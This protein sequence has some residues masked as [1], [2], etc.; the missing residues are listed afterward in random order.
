MTLKIQNTASEREQRD[1]PTGISTELISKTVCSLLRY[2]VQALYDGLFIPDD[3]ISDIER[4][5]NRNII[6][7]AD[8]QCCPRCLK[9]YVFKRATE[10]GLSDREINYLKIMLPG[11]VGHDGYYLD[12]GE[13]IPV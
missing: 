8:Y 1:Y 5:M 11:D 13:V 3:L 10:F 4:F 6:E 12:V 9:A 7:E 2:K